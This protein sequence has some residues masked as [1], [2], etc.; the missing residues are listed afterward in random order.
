LV[1]GVRDGKALPAKTIAPTEMVD[2]T[3]WEQAG[4]PCA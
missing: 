2:A 4:V 3:S 1:A